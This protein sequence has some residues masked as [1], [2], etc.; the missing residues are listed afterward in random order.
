MKIHRF[1]VDVL[2]GCT[3]KT[4]CWRDYIDI[5]FFLVL[6]CETHVRTLSKHFRY[7]L[8]ANYVGTCTV[9]VK[10]QNNNCNGQE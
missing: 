3:S 5:N 6:D 1:E 9:V 2:L 7:T 8:Y 10:C 4:K